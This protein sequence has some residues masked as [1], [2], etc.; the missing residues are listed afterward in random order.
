MTKRILVILITTLLSVVVPGSAIAAPNYESGIMEVQQE[1]NISLSYSD[2]I[3]Y[4]NGAEGLTL[5]VVSLTGKVVMEVKIETPAQKVELNIQK[6]CYIV[7]V[8]K[9]VR[10]V[11]E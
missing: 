2:G 11:R 1:R 3:L 6:G 4:V 10:K 8:G 7:K 5:E 9:A